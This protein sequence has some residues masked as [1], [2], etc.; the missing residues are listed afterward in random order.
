M[1][2]IINQNMSDMPIKKEKKVI[3]S[4]KI[5]NENAEIKNT[6]PKNLKI[7]MD[8]KDDSEVNKTSPNS[9]YESI[10]SMDFNSLLLNDSNHPFENCNTVFGKDIQNQ[11]ISPEY[12]YFLCNEEDI[13]EKNP[14]GNDYK[15]KSKNF[16]HKNTLNS[17]NINI[18]DLDLT[19]INDILK[20]I[21]YVQENINNNQINTNIYI[22]DN[23]FLN[24]LSD[25]QIETFNI[26]NNSFNSYINSNTFNCKSIIY[27]LFLF[28]S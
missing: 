20:D 17:K 10:N 27:N 7:Q 19:K 15:K 8:D 4:K 22:E 24:E 6:K 23:K 13:K 5:K 9:T 16:V 26:E 14:E 11:K 1:Y 3:L 18:E 25:I 28:Y 2:I 12:N 21:E